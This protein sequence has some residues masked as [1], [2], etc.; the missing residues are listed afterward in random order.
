MKNKRKTLKGMTLMEIIISLAILAVLTLV[1]VQTSTAINTYTRSAKNINQKVAS[2]APV[3]EMG[4]KPGAVAVSTSAVP[5]IFVNW[6]ANTLATTTGIDGSTEAVAPTGT[7]IVMD[8]VAYQ[9]GEIATTAIY[10]E[11]GTV[12]KF[13]RYEEVNELGGNLV[14]QFLD[15]QA[16]IT[17]ATTAVTTAVTTS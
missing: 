13:V 12:T 17:T 6:D 1:L 4:Y 10:T 11:E 8:A 5:Q 2:Q 9:V 14:M 16:P 7:A 15:V 3:A